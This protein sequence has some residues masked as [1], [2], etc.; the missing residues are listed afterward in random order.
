MGWA[1][2]VVG[3]LGMAGVTVLAIAGGGP[4]A[5]TVLGTTTT[6]VCAVGGTLAAHRR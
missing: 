3:V 6:A 1:T 4:E 5:A 2:L